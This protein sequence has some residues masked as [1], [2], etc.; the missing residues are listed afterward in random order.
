M[1]MPLRSLLVLATLLALTSASRAQSELQQQLKDTD[2]AP[3]WIYDDLPKALAEAKSTGKP[4]L[5]VLRCVPCPPGKTLDAQVMKPD[6]DLEKLEKQFVCVR[7]VQTKGLDLKIFQF[8]YDQSWCAV[9]MNAD[10][11]I[12]GRYGTRNSTGPKS[13]GWLTLPSFRK[14][15]ERALELHKGYPAN[16]DLIA[17]KIGKPQD[18]KFPEEIPGL[19]DR[20]KGVTTRQT[21]I[22][23]HMVREYMIRAKWQDKKLTASDLYVYPLPDSIGLAM[24]I[25][26]GL[27]VKSVAADS[28]AAK[29]GLA[30]GDELVTMAGQRLISLADIQWVLH[31]APEEAKLAV[32][33]RRESQTID[34]TITLSGTWKESDLNW[35]ASSWYGLRQGL[36]VDPLSAADKQKQGIAAGDLGLAVKGLFGRG[37]PLLQKAGLKAGDVIV[38]V[39]GKTADMTESQF[40][41]YL[42]L[43]H[44]PDDSVKFAILRGKERQELTIPMW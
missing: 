5:V 23:C 4:I 38:A 28:P 41:A 14:A 30:A 44:G 33:L 11:Q 42:R 2:L 18:Y 17:G 25:D 27:R 9:F 32:S 19:Q 8:D 29:A 10:Q 40:L 24:D 35:R 3:H 7:V 39:D 15:M 36:K 1:R 22:H 26:D 34:K 21:C 13:D 6:A 37:A 43:K 31:T 20:G 16:K 12:Y